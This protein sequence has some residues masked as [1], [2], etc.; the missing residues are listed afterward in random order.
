MLCNK[1][2]FVNS[3]FIYFIGFNDT[4]PLVSQGSDISILLCMLSL[5]VMIQKNK[6]KSKQQNL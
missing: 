2:T 1:V 4:V 6:L 5:K 3:I